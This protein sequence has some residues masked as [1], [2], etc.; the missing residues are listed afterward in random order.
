MKEW[1]KFWLHL[2]NWL[3][4]WWHSGNLLLFCDLNRAYTC[5]RIAKHVLSHMGLCLHIAAMGYEILQHSDTPFW[6]L[7]EI[8]SELI[9]VRVKSKDAHIFQNYKKLTVMSKTIFVG[10]VWSSLWS[11]NFSSCFFRKSATVPISH[12]L[13]HCTCNT[14][15]MSYPIALAA[16][17]SSGSR[18]MSL[19]G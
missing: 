4:F 11:G 12:L 13:K 7:T 15:A 6:V 16:P 2:R 14:K 8:L 9:N 5:E 3:K 1:P 18:V 10:V 17:S 19:P